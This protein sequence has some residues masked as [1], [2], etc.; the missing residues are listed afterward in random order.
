MFKDNPFHENDRKMMITNHKSKSVQHNY[1]SIQ[2]TY[3]Q[4]TTH[5]DTIVNLKIR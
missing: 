1:Y 3:F 2:S 4:S 5:L